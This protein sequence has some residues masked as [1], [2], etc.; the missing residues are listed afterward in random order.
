MRPG[1][2]RRRIRLVAEPGAVRGDMED[3]PHR[4]GVIVRHDG[5]RVTGIQGIPLRTP[6]DLC[7]GAAARLQLIVGAELS[8]DPLSLHRSLA[9]AQQ[10]THMFDLA[11][12]AVAHAARGTARR[13]Y[14]IEAPV[15]EAAGRRRLTLR[16]DGE[17]VLEWIVE[18]SNIVA[19]E[20]Y[21]GQD[22]RAM[23]PWAA[24]T[25]TDPD[26]YEAI[27]VLRRTVLISLS[28]LAHLD[29]HERA[30]AFPGRMGGCWVYQAGNVERAIRRMGS[31][32][33]FTSEPD[34]LLQDIDSR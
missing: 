12:L 33:D 3:D 15:T 17:P 26:V 8:L 13:Q 10:C 25:F 30:T 19:P 22:A 21:V 28:R 32:R 20:P 5:E 24:R 1:I 18:G 29:D 11:G 2:Y 34:A 27:V 7:E 14:D 31:T 6:W 23:L 4:F 16:L 9:P